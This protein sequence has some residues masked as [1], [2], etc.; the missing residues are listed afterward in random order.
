[1]DGWTRDTGETE[2]LS[3]QD[4]RAL[5]TGRGDLAG[6]GFAALLNTFEDYP[7]HDCTQ[8]SLCG[9]GLT[10]LARSVEWNPQDGCT[11]LES[12]EVEIK[13]LAKELD[14]CKQC[15]GAMLKRDVAERM[16]LWS[17]LLSIFGLSKVEC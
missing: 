16:S 8:P 2:Y 1:M 15:R 13:R 3:M 10:G 6:R 17:M 5:I 14:I 11:V 12:W 4:L 7:A 9:I